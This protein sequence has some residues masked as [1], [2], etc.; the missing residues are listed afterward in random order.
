[1]SSSKLFTPIRVGASNLSHRIVLAPLTRYRANRDH[2]HGDL[3]IKY[4]EQ[5]ASK[6]GTLLITEATFIAPEAGGYRNVPG[7]WN[8]DQVEAWKRVTTAVHDK[9]SYIYLQLW[10]T[11]RQAMPSILK[12][13]G[14]YPYVSSSDVAMKG[15]TPPRPLTK[16]EIK[17]YVG[18]F[19]KAAENALEAGFDGVEVHG[20]NGYL[21]DQFIQDVCNKRTDEYGGSVENRT[22]F[23][24]EVTDAVTH[25]VGQERTGIRLSPWS[26]FGDMRE[27]DPIPTFSYLVQQLY[28]RY[29]QLSYL[30]LIEP[31][32]GGD[33]DAR[34]DG[35]TDTTQDSNEFARKIWKDRPLISAGG[36]QPETAK[37][38]VEKY[39][40]LVAFGRWYISNPDLPR[41]IELGADLNEYNRKTFYK[42][43]SPEGYIDYP[44]L[45]SK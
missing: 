2:V 22:R 12:Q 24:L 8:N 27:R 45:D 7:I 37:Q 10:A 17:K 14:G 11:G 4:Y 15:R 23:A 35:K 5:R 41:R 42:P 6:P 43:E 1:M 16:D 18:L 44:F 38:Y 31:R 28:D 29:P 25:A 40:G 20:A 3:A 19:S 34:D 30:H 26:T 9:Q 32:V 39:D 13:E 33:S 36:Y 21:I